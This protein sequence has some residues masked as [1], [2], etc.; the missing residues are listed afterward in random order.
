VRWLGT[1]LPDGWTTQW[2]VSAWKEFQLDAILIVTVEVVF[3]VVFL[4]PL[5]GVPAAYA[6][7]SQLPRQASADAALPCR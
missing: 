4:A 6:G 2:Y 5:I 3:A 7:A 1:W